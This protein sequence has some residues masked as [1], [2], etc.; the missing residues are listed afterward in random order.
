MLN[1]PFIRDK[2]PALQRIYNSYPMIFL[3][4][5]GGT[6]VPVDVINAVS[7]YYTTSNSNT[8]G[9]FITTR[10][11]DSILQQARE[12]T[13]TL[14]GA[15]GAH[16]ISFG[17]NMT[18]L[19]FSLAHG[20][21]RVLQPGDEVLITQLDHEGN[22]GPWLVLRERGIIV[23]EICM[24]QDGTLD[25]DDLE[26]K[27]NERTRLV[28]MGM[29]SNAL[30]TVN[31]VQLARKLTHRYNAWLMVDA[32]AYAPHFSIDVQQLGCDFLLCSAYKF[33]GPHAGI[34]YSKPGLLNSIRADRLR[35][36]DQQAPFCIETGTLNHAAIAGVT[37]AVHFIAA[38]GAGANLR[39]SLIDAYRQLGEHEH[40]LAV[41]LYNG[42][43]QMKGVDM[44]GQDFSSR[45][46][47][48]TVSFTVEG[49]TAQQVCAHLATKN[50]C[51]W[52]G[53]FYAIRAIQVLGLLEKGGLTR[54]GMSIY[55]TA[56]EIDITLSHLQMILK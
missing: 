21:G 34:L 18:T 8:H 13:A 39:E 38:Q 9:E 6:Q 5:P 54:M 43:K 31:N 28:A 42:L 45:H 32:V 41:Q 17:Q 20:I 47:S 14:L 1:T 52:D 25:Y 12:A 27:I 30:G 51:A 4:G 33:Y 53:H 55:N 56:E 48:P 24:N 49:K 15:E 10:E 29:A 19:N 50:I 26:E 40:A 46:R 7:G 44:V 35:T 23:R 22:R 37:A 36:A 11:T 2:F 16:T 3:D